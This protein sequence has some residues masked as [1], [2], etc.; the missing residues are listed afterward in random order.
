MTLKA[1]EDRIFTA[2]R[3][4]AVGWALSLGFAGVLA[5]NALN[6]S[7]LHDASGHLIGRDFILFWMGGRL[8]VT[9]DAAQAYDT[10]AVA[11]NL[12]GYL[13]L[14]EGG[15]SSFRLLYPPT[16]LLILWPL[17]LLNYSAA[18]TLWIAGTGGL[19]LSA[20]YRIVPRGAILLAGFSLY[21]AEKNLFWGQGGFLIA[22]LLALALQLF[23]R[24]PF[25]GGLVLGLLTVKPQYGVLFPIVLAASGQ[26]RA[27][28]GACVSSIALAGLTTACYGL[29]IWAA[30]SRSLGLVSPDSLAAQSDFQVVHQTLFGLAYWAD[31]GVAAQW[32]FQL[33]GG[34]LATVL[35][36]IIWRRPVSA[37]LKASALGAGVLLATPYMLAY[38]LTAAIV[39]AAFL[40][41]EGLETGFRPGER[42]V[43]VACFLGLV[44]TEF[45]PIGPVIVVTLLMLTARRVFASGPS[46]GLDVQGRPAENA[47]RPV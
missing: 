12:T 35:I 18:F 27:I 47:P 23:D 6:H 13:D 3:L 14:A 30:F 20:L 32:A 24:R 45:G 44:L 29:T 7:W 16:L 2:E 38:D 17:G 39:P 11:A 34:G 19:Y 9:H 21:V 41:R 4:L 37:A 10:A 42:F 22:G 43:L 28:A 1:L 25:I 33:A 40:V 46:L 26:W 31:A 8:A 5:L 15:D 36:C